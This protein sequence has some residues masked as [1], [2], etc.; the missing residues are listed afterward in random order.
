MRDDTIVKVSAIA[1]LTI[2]GVSYFYFV[3]QDGT[4]LLTLSSI[5]GGI[6]GYVIGKQR[7]QS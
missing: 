4:V 1:G 2:L 6:A 7:R 3:R 5:I